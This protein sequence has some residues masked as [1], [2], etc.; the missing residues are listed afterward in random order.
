MDPSSSSDIT[1]HSIRRSFFHSF[2]SYEQPASVAACHSLLCSALGFWGSSL[3]GGG[4]T[5]VGL[6]QYIF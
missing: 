2:L 1:H 5:V 6:R 3:E 4:D